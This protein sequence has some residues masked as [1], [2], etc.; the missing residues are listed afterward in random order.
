MKQLQ[1]TV[2]GNGGRGDDLGVYG[3]MMVGSLRSEL[4]RGHRQFMSE[5]KQ[6][7]PMIRVMGTGQGCRFSGVKES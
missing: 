5:L 7:P 3:D 2:P 1:G 4:R 6:Q